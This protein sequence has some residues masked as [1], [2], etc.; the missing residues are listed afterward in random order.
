MP[1]DA[2]AMKFPSTDPSAASISSGSVS[3][4]SDQQQQH[5]LTHGLRSQ[6]GQ[7]LPRHALFHAHVTIEQL[8]N[9][10]LMRGEFAVRWK[11]KH[12]QSRS[13]LL[14]KMKKGSSSHGFRGK[15][16]GRADNL[17][18]AIEVTPAEGDHAGHGG[19]GTNDADTDGESS[20]ANE[21]GTGTEDE[22]NSPE[23][24]RNSYGDLLT[25]HP[26][27]P[28]TAVPPASPASTPTPRT[29]PI[30]KTPSSESNESCAVARGATPWRPLQSY[31]VKWDHNV[32]VLVQMHVHRE[33]RALLPNELKL[34]V[35]QRVI[36][37]DPD[38]PRQPRLGAIYLNLAEYADAGPVTRRYLLRES[39]TNAT[40]KLTIELTHAGG[41]TDYRPPPLHKSEILASVTGL[42]EQNDRLRTSL[43]RE[44]DAYT[45]PTPSSPSSSLPPEGSAE[46]PF[47]RADGTPDG[48]RLAYAHGLRD[49]EALIETL[50]NPV[51]VSTRATD[52]SPFTYY[53]PVPQSPAPSAPGLG[54]RTCSRS[55]STDASSVLSVGACSVRSMSVS[56]GS[57]A[58]PRVSVEKPAVESSPEIP[59]ATLEHGEDHRTWWRKIRSR[60]GTPVGRTYKLPLPRQTEVANA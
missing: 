4:I 34:I 1:P 26:H 40:L 30:H 18:L 32:R 12:V 57:D 58:G 13:R 19:A 51:P 29:Q 48:E 55:G 6:F 36:P 25:A 21:A 39:K 54:E 38:A 23:T 14:S 46:H 49:T 24:H 31:N 59:V 11:F 9:V 5:A 52:P 50:F 15:G 10:P 60:P 17:G 28:G 20:A 41:T 2:L 42:L 44:V 22:M 27:T 45:Y 16:K 33:T 53:A 8:S 43:A 3:I 47:M 7:L 35:M 37:G 56:G